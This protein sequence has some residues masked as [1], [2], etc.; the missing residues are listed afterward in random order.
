MALKIIEIMIKEGSDFLGTR[1]TEDEEASGIQN[2]RVAE[3]DS[4]PE[5]V[6]VS[7]ASANVV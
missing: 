5:S 7:C 1:A 2:S 4:A 3:N 6:R